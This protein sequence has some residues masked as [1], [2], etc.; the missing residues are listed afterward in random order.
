MPDTDRHLSEFAA[1][2]SLAPHTLNT[3]TN[4]ADLCTVCGCASPCK[5][6]VLGEHNLETLSCCQSWNGPASTPTEATAGPAFHSLA[7]T[8]RGG[9]GR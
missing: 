6:A 4:D 7:T 9:G 8:M 5:R 3:H 2:I 1:L